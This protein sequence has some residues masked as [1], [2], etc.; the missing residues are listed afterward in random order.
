MSHIVSIKT[1]VRDSEGVKAAC[2]RLGLAEPVQGTTELYQAQ[3]TGL[4]VV[5]PGWL[6]PV[7]IDTT[8]ASPLRQLRSAQA[9]A[10]LH[11]LPRRMP[12][13]R[14]RGPQRGQRRRT[15]NADGW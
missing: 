9:L 11:H 5:L 1:E 10:Q 4:L 12:W 7:V 13:R 15:V 2:H 3:A 8:T 14:H 6:Y